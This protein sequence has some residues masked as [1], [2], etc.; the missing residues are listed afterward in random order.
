MEITIILDDE[1]Q[2]N[3]KSLADAQYKTEAEYAAHV[4]K[5]HVMRDLKDKAISDF[6]RLPE[7][8]IKTVAASIKVAYED[9]YPVIKDD[10]VIDG[11]P[12][13]KAPLP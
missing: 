7:Q 3:L 11:N 13:V 1:L 2:A 6:E 4:V 9:A 12:T 8:Q 10:V 5:K